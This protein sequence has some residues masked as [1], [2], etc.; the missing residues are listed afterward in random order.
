MMKK[1]VTY[2]LLIVLLNVFNVY[3]L[4]AKTSNKTNAL[5][6]GFITPP[7]SIQ[8]SC[9]WYW[10]SNNI[11]KEGVEKDMI[12][13]KKAGINRAFIGNI[14]LDDVPYGKVKMLTDEWWEILHTALKKAT[15]L[16]IDI[17]IF[18]SPGW[19]QSG[20]PWVK[21]TAAMRY[22]TSSQMMVQGPIKLVQKLDKPTPDFHDV[23]LIAYPQPK[24][25]QC[26]LD[27]INATLTS[28]P[29]VL[30]LKNIVDKN[31]QTSISFPSGKS[32]F[33]IYFKSPKE[34]TARYIS[35]R[36]SNSPTIID[37]ELQV[38]KGN[39]YQLLKSFKVERYNESLAV[40]FEPYSAVVETFEPCVANEFCVVIR[41]CNDKQGLSEVHIGAGAKVERYAEK[42]FA[43]MLQTPF[44]SWHDYLW[45]PQ[46][47][48]YD[49]NLIIQPNQIMDISKYMTADGLL[50]WDVPAGNWIIERTGMTPTGTK[51]S[52]AAPEATGFEV[53]KMS[54]E[55][56]Q[57]HFYGHIGEILKRIP[58]ADRKSFKVV[59]QDSYEMGGQN[60]TDRFFEA[61]EKEFGYSALPF[62]PVYSGRTV[63]SQDMSD[64]FL[65]DM[66]RLV[67]NM[68]AIEYVGGMKEVSNKH[69]L[70]TWLENYGH[71]GFPG[72]SLLYGAY[73]DEI[74]GEFWVEGDLGNIENRIATSCGHIYGKNKISAESYTCAG[75]V[76]ERN[77]AMIKQ[78]GDRFFA[79]GI[80]NSLLHVWISQPDDKL[81]GINAWFG[82]EFNKSE[83]QLFIS[84]LKRT[85]YMLQQ[86]L[87][88]ADVA[89]FTGE[90]APRMTGITDPALPKG[91]QFDYINYDVIMNRL[92]VK[93]GMLTLPHGT[94]YR[95]LVLPKLETMR[96]ELLA[97]IKQLI[98]EGAVV[99]GPAPK[100]SPSLKGYPNADVKIE[101]LAK[102]IWSDMDGIK[103]QSRKL[104]KGLV[105]S[106]MDMTK[107]LELINCSPDCNIENTVKVDYGHRKLQNGDVYY[108]TNQSEGKTI[109]F[110]PEFRVKG[111]KPELWLP[112]TGEI[113][114][115]PVFYQT[116]TGTIVPL[117]LE[118]NESM[119][120]VFRSSSENTKMNEFTS[121]FPKPTQLTQL[122]APWMVN[123]TD[124]LRGPKQAVV[125][126]KLYDWTTSND[127]KIKYY[128]GSAIYKST[129]KVDK[130]PSNKLIYLNFTEVPNL[131]KVKINGKYLGG[132]WTPPYRLNINDAIKKGNNSIEIEVANNWLNRLQ[133]D[134]KLPEKERT[135][136]TVHYPNPETP[137]Q[138]SGLIG[139]ITIDF[140]QNN[141]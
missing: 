102:E 4:N 121:N 110:S 95:M 51:N 72:E 129:F 17:G 42:T 133:G 127:H 84:Y 89:Y 69:G 3:E 58:E 68:I 107:A 24:N 98:E 113:R 59:V 100:R 141:K 13:M 45:K 108:L 97:K 37:V 49:A 71:W 66:R 35:I 23:K 47:Q 31:N 119:F 5:P 92:S 56:T 106:N 70:T 73:S 25:D 57:M 87:N 46:S 28:I 105:I 54:K 136:W 39:S 90:D 79:E 2:F 103:T 14:G 7:D 29:Q 19:S 124:T 132:V 122:T 55:H 130:L 109:E 67:A 140:V 120:I 75:R 123:F 33:E 104:G 50:S 22:L 48:I 74:G 1:K 10:L 85:N 91:Y 44:P 32:E 62:L 117:V 99:Y 40:G 60:F 101:K 114:A 30:N 139:P 118:P 82:T 64:R 86:G 126:N 112:T 43:K 80:N 96:P 65:W 88:V 128:S 6:S 116:N 41:N 18:N 36:T 16:G 77:P 93:D 9:Y 111:M 52:P 38:K 21:N 138:K 53:D 137:L 78:R 12:A 131:A 83:I 61:F 8:T 20:G 125:F 94:Q 15:E 134:S 11:S 76:F 81:P 135:T 27:T 26:V 63:G 115:L 34:F